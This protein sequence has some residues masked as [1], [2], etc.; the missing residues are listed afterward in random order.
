MAMALRLLSLLMVFFMSLSSELGTK[1]RVWGLA[2][3]AEFG[4]GPEN[5]EERDCYQPKKEIAFEM[6]EA[7]VYLLSRGYLNHDVHFPR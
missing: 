2:L 1:E 7:G 3:A 4:P 5:P 6:L